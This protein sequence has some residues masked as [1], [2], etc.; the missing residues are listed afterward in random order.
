[1]EI[2]R[3]TQA[4]YISEIAILVVSDDSLN[5]FWDAESAESNDKEDTAAGSSK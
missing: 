1:M 5:A 2:C 3:K 4:E